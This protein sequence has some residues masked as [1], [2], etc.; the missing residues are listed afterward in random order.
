M[1]VLVLDG[2][3]NQAVAAVR[4]L[5]RAGHFVAVGAATPW[6]KAGWSRYCR[7]MF[8]YPAPQQDVPGFVGRIAE[9]VRRGK[10]GTMVMPMTERTTLPLSANRDLIFAAGG[11]MELP[12]HDILLR[13][14]DKE[15]TTQ[16]ARS[17][18]IQV[19]HTTL[20]ESDARARE[21]IDALSYPVVLK[22]RS[23]E[24]VSGD[25][26]VVAT[27]API[28]A[29]D[30]EEFAAAYAEISSRCSAVL[31]Q[32]FVAGV[33]AGYFALMRDGE[34][35]A[36]FAHRRLRDVRPAGSGSALRVS[37]LPESRVREAALAI[38]CGLRWH[39]VAMVEF[40]VRAD[41]TPVFLEVNGRFW[42]SLPLAVYSGADFPAWLAEMAD[43]GNVRSPIDYRAGVQCR[44]L[45]GD[46]RH[47]LEVWRG[48]PQGFPGSF[49]R[50]LPTL[51]AFLTPTAGTFHDNFTWRDP[52]PEFGDWLDFVFRR[53][54]AG[55]RRSTA[56]G[57]DLHAEGRYSHS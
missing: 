27:G 26:K 4:S 21:L 30:A 34:L 46:V 1:K 37:A 22:P 16:L 23:S 43:H 49:P 14:F 17:L 54:P 2:N 11:R 15:Q 35:C 47:L 13:A 36:E 25:N 32:E 28:Y 56:A 7:E 51:A 48:A 38:L 29:R 42:N 57:K 10:P 40:R 53:L 39:G 44:W 24:E 3:E 18:G 6:S 12:S 20:V 19:P 33:G 50:R 45:L 52:L 8:T 31:V 9:E 5:A 55:A 41:G